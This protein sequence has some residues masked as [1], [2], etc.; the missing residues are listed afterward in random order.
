MANEGRQRQKD[1]PNQPTGTSG[2]QRGDA[3]TPGQT[4]N[5]DARRG[6]TSPAARKR[7]SFDEDE[8]S[9]LGN[10]TTYR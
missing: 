3:N 2:R 6:E 7:S 9:A 10:K 1:D 4:D 5:N 8:D